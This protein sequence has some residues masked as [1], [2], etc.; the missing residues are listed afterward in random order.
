MIKNVILFHAM[1]ATPDSYWYPYLKYNLEQKDFT[2][3][4]PVLPNTDKADIKDWLPV[5]LKERFD[6]NTILIGHSAGCPLIL[7]VLEN[8]QVRIK[9]VIMVAGFFEPLEIPEPI[10]QENYAWN[11]IK[12]H[13]QEFIFINSDN[14]PW[15][16]NDIVGRKLLDH[17]GGKL[18]I[19]KG[20]GHMGSDSFKQPYREFPFLLKL[21]D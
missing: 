5:A 6:E 17:L 9:Q 18:I 2:V 8:I 10:L 4:I 15:G 1:G 21:I 11:K 16:C 13:S 19:P 3:S 7:S 20:E 12:D 14:D